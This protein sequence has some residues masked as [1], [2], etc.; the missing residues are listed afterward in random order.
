MIFIKL[1]NVKNFYSTEEL[2][3]KYFDDMF[4]SALE[5]IL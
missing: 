4:L 1:Y 3:S 5:F 2:L